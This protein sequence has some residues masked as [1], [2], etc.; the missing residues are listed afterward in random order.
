[1]VI[2]SRIGK[3]GRLGDQLLYLKRQLLDKSIVRRGWLSKDAGL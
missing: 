3:I 1:M 2:E